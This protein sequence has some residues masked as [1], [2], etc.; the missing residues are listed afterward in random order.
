M[1]K[2]TELFDKLAP[3]LATHGSEL[4]KKANACYLFE[5][6]P[7]KHSAPVLTTVNLRDGNGKLSL[8]LKYLTYLT[9][10]IGKISKGSVGNIDATFCMS[11]DDFMALANRKLNSKMAYMTVSYTL[12]YCIVIG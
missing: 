7:D 4:V 10:I 2:S 12:K 3:L 6:K 9:L 1:S 5:I 11:D 8:I